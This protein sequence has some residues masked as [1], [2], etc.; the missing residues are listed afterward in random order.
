MTGMTGDL[1]TPALL[2]DESRARRNIERMAERARRAGVRL[3]PHM[4][5][6]DSPDVGAWFRDAG[7]EAITVSSLS[8]ARSF[9]QAG[10]RDV[11]VAFPFN[12]RELD[13]ARELA[14][15]VDLGLLVDHETPVNAL[16]AAGI[17]PVRVWIK[18]DTGLGRA[19]IPWDEPDR[20]V[21]LA[22]RIAGSRPLL[23]AG[24]LTHAGHSY[25]ERSAAG[26]LRVHA[27]S[28]RRMRKAKTALE[29]EGFDGLEISV[30]DTPTCSLAEDFPGAGEIRPG[31]FVFFDLMQLAVGSCGPEDLALALACPVAGVHPKRGEIV[32]YGGAIHL[33]KEGLVREDGSRIFG[34][35]ASGG[36][37]SLGHPDKTAPVV[38]LSQEHGVARVPPDRSDGLSIG[39][40]VTVFPV[41]ACLAANLHRG[42]RT[43]EGEALR[44]FERE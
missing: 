27:E 33:S 15:R 9:A 2:V 42:Y 7:V 28:L 29:D 20:A 34:A 25:R 17:D 44:R 40:L 26:V 19:G 6:H 37:G 38:D 21:S 18:I 12:V 41:H 14:S 13:E 30:G 3:R 8:M 5:T 16:A 11:T 22:R 31:N 10:W 23:L 36:K 24:L 39:D 1:K 35:L 32:I 43:L 4:K